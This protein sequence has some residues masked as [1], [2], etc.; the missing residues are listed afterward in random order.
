[1]WMNDIGRKFVILGILFHPISPRSRIL[2]VGWLRMQ[3]PLAPVL[4]LCETVGLSTTVWVQ[5]ALQFRNVMR[6]CVCAHLV[7][8]H[9]TPRAHRISVRHT[10]DERL[11]NLGINL[12]L[13]SLEV[14]WL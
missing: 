8:Q 6:K 9:I 12:L 3:G 5:D 11:G 2:K 7:S 13:A 1:M 4:V 14:T 10:P